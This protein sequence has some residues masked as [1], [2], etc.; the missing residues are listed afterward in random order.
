MIRNLLIITGVGFVLALVGIT[1][2]F[3]LV[4]NDVRKHDWT[5]VIDDDAAG[6]SSFR[7]Q[8]GE[9]APEVT[10]NIEWAGGDRL[11]VDVPGKVTYVQGAQAGI[12]VTG[13]KDIV[14]SI[15]FNDGR[16]TMISDDNHDRGYIRWSGSGIRVWSESEALR[17]EVTA[18]AV[19]RF[20]M[21]DNGEL[22]IR[23]YDQPTLDVVINGEGSVK[24]D[25]QAQRVSVVSSGDGDASLRR[26]MT[27][28]A[29]V[30]STGRGDVSVA[31]TGRA[32]IEI[33]GH[34]DVYLARNPAQ[35]N[36]SITGWG[37]VEMD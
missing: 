16:L 19:N 4:G 21:G 30:R 37:E 26:V 29:T 25:G 14:D 2:A 9:V 3:A 20:E 22:N 15:R 13:P 34:G 12:R 31:P 28:D 33:A 11:M 23:G 6:D 7:I 36:Q 27:T 8:R 5:W 10:R 18:P 24:A 32:D 17:I 1:G 35:L